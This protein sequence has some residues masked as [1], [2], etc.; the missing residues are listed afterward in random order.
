MDEE[1]KIAGEWVRAL[2]W[3]GEKPS[4]P[5]WYWMKND[6]YLT[7]PTVTMIHQHQLD[8]WGRY[9]KSSGLKGDGEWA[10][11]IEEPS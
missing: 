4:M 9:L 3:T 1:G 8:D 10:G 5:G 2:K 7:G 6:S 11:P